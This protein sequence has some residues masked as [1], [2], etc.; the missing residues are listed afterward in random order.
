MI[1]GG[2]FVLSPKVID[3]I[4]DDDSHLGAR[5]ARE[6]GGRRPADGVRARRLLA[7]DGHAARQALT[8]KS[9]GN[10]ASAPW[11]MWDE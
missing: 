5:A 2:F 1:N 6:P 10:P 8:S 3:L 9:C 4:P 11:K 7:A